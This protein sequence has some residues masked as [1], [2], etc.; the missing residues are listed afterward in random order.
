MT[1]HERHGIWQAAR[2]LVERSYTTEA[3]FLPFFVAHH[4]ARL[5]AMLRS[6]ERT[7][8]PAGILVVLPAAPALRRAAL[9]WTR[10]L[11]ERNIR[12]TLIRATRVEETQVDALVARSSAIV[13]PSPW[14]RWAE[15][16]RRN[17]VPCA[18]IADLDDGRL[19]QPVPSH[20]ARPDALLTLSRRAAD[21]A[22]AAGWRTVWHVG[23]P[24]HHRSGPARKAFLPITTPRVAWVV[25]DDA[26]AGVAD[27]IQ[28]VL[29]HQGC[30]IAADH[31]HADLV[32][33]AGNGA[34]IM[35]AA[36]TA[37]MSGRVVVAVCS[38]DVDEM[39]IPRVNGWSIRSGEP[40][41]DV[42]AEAIR[43]IAS[44]A[45]SMRRAAEATARSRTRPDAIL[46]DLI[47]ALCDTAGPA[48]STGPADHDPD[49]RPDRQ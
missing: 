25:A 20:D 8:D 33:L 41:S 46:H 39:V 49:R 22:R 37:M 34:A 36:L 7:A 40:L 17:G 5:H 24:L 29:S 6:R 13:A 35:D 21:V 31:R 28:A 11:R 26:P 23:S 15:A 48:H 45:A 19:H 32:I 3:Q 1:D 2:Q 4:V 9:G 38:S 18:A 27:Q 14:S 47:C 10:L 42:I 16:A 12:V 30:Q 44:G 43:S